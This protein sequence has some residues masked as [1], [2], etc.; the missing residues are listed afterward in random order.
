MFLGAANHSASDDVNISMQV[1]GNVTSEND[2]HANHNENERPNEESRGFFR[3]EESETENF[4]SNF[5]LREA[6]N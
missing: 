1:G 6:C 5:L 4:P 2:H 3:V